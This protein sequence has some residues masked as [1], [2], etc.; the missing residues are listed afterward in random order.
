MKI[1]RKTWFI[2][3]GIALILVTNAIVLGGVAYNR[4]QAVGGQLVLSER[5]LLVRGNRASNSENSG[6]QLYL[7]IRVP[8]DTVENGLEYGDTRASWL[9]PEK[10]RT[11]G[12]KFPD[13]LK[14]SIDEQQI[15]RIEQKDVYVVLEF[16]GDVYKRDV[17]AALT[18]ATNAQEK[19]ATNP[20]DKKLAE[21][22]K[23]SRD[24]ADREQHRASRLY[25]I[26][27]GLDA[28]AL[29]RQYPDR[30]KY[31]VMIGKI[32][33]SW[34]ISNNIKHVIGMFSGLRI[35]NI[36]V[37]LRWRS[38]LGTEQQLNHYTPYSLY[39]LTRENAN[40]DSPHF[41]VTL[42][43]GRRFE[44]WIIDIKPIQ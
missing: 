6:L 15:N 16:S 13:K 30:S 1:N 27:A 10:L 33:L 22:A 29:L 41:N 24:D 25:C 9:T 18:D 8:V 26:D 34:T 42:A 4:S 11:L 2:I 28:N 44:P 21:L 35:D 5:E 12:F 3:A 40:D 38:S 20:D 39:N 14:S 32:D 19:A 31:V 36:N 43:W 7:R 17:Q 37:P 23:S